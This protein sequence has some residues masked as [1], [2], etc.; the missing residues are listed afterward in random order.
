MFVLLHPIPSLFQIPAARTDTLETV[1]FVDV[2]PTIC[3][4]VASVEET[5]WRCRRDV[6]LQSQSPPRPPVGLLCRMIRA[7]PEIRYEYGYIQEPYH[8]FHPLPLQQSSESF[9]LYPNREET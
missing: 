2:I 5:L 9:V 3:P 6:S 4:L 1:H 8:T 7:T